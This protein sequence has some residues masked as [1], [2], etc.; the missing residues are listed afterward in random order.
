[1]SPHNNTK[2]FFCLI[3]YFLPRFVNDI[4]ITGILLLCTLFLSTYAYRS[5]RSRIDFAKVIMKIACEAVLAMPMTVVVSV[6]CMLAQTL[7]ML[8]WFIMSTYLA[9]NSNQQTVTSE[10]TGVIYSLT[11][12]KQYTY[13]GSISL[14]SNTIKLSCTSAPCYACVCDNT[15]VLQD[16]ECYNEIIYE[17]PYF[18][19]I[20]SLIFTCTVITNVSHVTTAGSTCV[21]WAERVPPNASEIKE[22]LIRSF[23]CIGSIALGSLLVSTIKACRFFLNMIHKISS[24]VASRNKVTQYF[25]TC[26][27]NSLLRVEQVM[28][29]INK[30]AFV[31]LAMYDSYGF[32]DASIAVSNLFA[33]RGFTAVV[34]DGTIDIVI[35]SAQSFVSILTVLIGYAY[36]IAVELDAPNTSIMVLFSFFAG[37]LMSS[38]ILSPVSSVCNTIFV[39][40]AESP[41]SFQSA[42]PNMSKELQ[43]AWSVVNGGSSSVHKD[44]VA[45]EERAYEPPTIPTNSSGYSKVPF[46]DV[47]DEKID[48]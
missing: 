24:T 4:V 19:L 38:V 18:I 22:Q 34:S 47:D 23:K 16:K 45:D 6:A 1:M 2:C 11:S 48:L 13:D 10:K 41:D 43:A 44:S 37:Y 32:F 26:I 28:I 40:F 5:I 8:F 21:W 15:L 20:A 30:Y 36:S 17:F 25:A 33:E 27:N 12:C 31:Y 14:A 39:C 29:F 35:L 42:H 9:T 3:P 7:Y 46:E